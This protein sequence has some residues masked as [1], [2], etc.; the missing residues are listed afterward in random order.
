MSE[1]VISV[2]WEY[3]AYEPDGPAG[4]IWILKGRYDGNTD[5]EPSEDDRARRVIGPIEFTLS[6]EIYKAMW[7]TLEWIGHRVEHHEIADD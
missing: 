3:N 2:I 6:V 1:S 5:P 4:T 7:S